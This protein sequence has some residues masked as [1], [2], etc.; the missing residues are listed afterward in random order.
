MPITSGN[1]RPWIKTLPGKQLV[2]PEPLTSHTGSEGAREIDIGISA[3]DSTGDF[4]VFIITSRSA[5]DSG[6]VEP[7]MKVSRFSPFVTPRN[8][9]WRSAV[10]KPLGSLPHFVAP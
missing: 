6:C 7:S 4:G 2:G 8:V 1:Q 9:Y 5:C 3:A 10:Y